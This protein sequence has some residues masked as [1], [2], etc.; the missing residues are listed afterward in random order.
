MGSCRIV[1]E[2]GRFNFS[3][4]IKSFSET[5]AATPN[6][7]NVI[8][9]TLFYHQRPKLRVLVVLQYDQSHQNELKVVIKLYKFVRCRLSCVSFCFYTGFIHT[10]H[11]LSSY[12]KSV[13]PFFHTRIPMTS[14]T[15]FLLTSSFLNPC[16]YV[17]SSEKRQWEKVT[18]C[19]G[20]VNTTNTTL[21][22][23]PLCV[24]EVPPYRGVQD[25]QANR[26]RTNTCTQSL[27]SI[28]QHCLKT[29]T[30]AC[31]WERSSRSTERGREGR[32]T[33]AGIWFSG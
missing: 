26:H 5:T 13:G 12:C 17:R 19:Q 28:Q 7:N 24:W 25:Y 11:S 2:Q 4:H 14:S 1:W 6:L 23:H 22:L 32:G 31:W 20:P 15:W 29:F 27:V 18:E 21:P 30:L 10:L 8:V 9:I 33:I 3:T 16:H